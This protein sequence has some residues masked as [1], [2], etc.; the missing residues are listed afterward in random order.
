M[1][2]QYQLNF[3]ALAALVLVVVCCNIL[4]AQTALITVS[5][6]NPSI[7]SPTE[8]EFDVDITWTGGTATSVELNAINVHAKVLPTA[9]VPTTPTVPVYSLVEM[10]PHFTGMNFPSNPAWNSAVPNLRAT[11]TPTGSLASAPDLV[12]GTTYKLFRANLTTSAP[13]SDFT[14]DFQ[15]PG[16]IPSISGSFYLNGGTTARTINFNGSNSGTPPMYYG[17]ITVGTPIPISFLP[18]EL[19]E[20]KAYADG[21]VNIIQ[22]KTESEANSQYHIVERSADGIDNWTEVGRKLA[23]GTTQVKQ[24]Y[25]LEDERPLPMSYYRLKLMDFD[26]KFEYSKV[27]SVERR[28]NDFGVVNLF[29]MP[30]S[31]KVTMQVNLPEFT[32]VKMSITDVNGRLLQVSD[33]ELEKGV[34]EVKV[35]LTRFAAGTYFV[36]LDNGVRQLTEQVVKQ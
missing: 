15:Q 20:V 11:Q 17:T 32:N 8:I 5:F 31:D 4:A 1:K 28:S 3:K 33:L 7:I 13:M 30:T 10:G 9:S 16:N 18:V 34:S 24:E 35:D 29:P 22:W 25:N 27:V 21:E 12:L 19:T 14:L 2:I 6:N 26:G 36:K 23:A